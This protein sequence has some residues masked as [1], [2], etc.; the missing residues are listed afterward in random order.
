MQLAFSLHHQTYR[1]TRGCWSEK[2]TNT[3]F[4]FSSQNCLVCTL[5]KNM[6]CFPK[7]T[8]IQII[9]YIFTTLVQS[10]NAVLQQI[11]PPTVPIYCTLAQL[12]EQFWC[13]E[14]LNS[15]CRELTQKL[16]SVHMECTPV[17]TFQV[18]TNQWAFGQLLG[19]LH[20]EKSQSKRSS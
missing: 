1:L 11:P 7:A 20:G 12:P 14:A 4:S 2:Y 17:R 16:C 3:H 13:T 10:S 15:L 9:A 18:Q 8:K 6:Q 19:S 5:E